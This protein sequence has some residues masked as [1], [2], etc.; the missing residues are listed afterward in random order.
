MEVAAATT[1]KKVGET[2]AAEEV[3]TMKVAVEAATMMVA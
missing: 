1:S 2:K 3:V